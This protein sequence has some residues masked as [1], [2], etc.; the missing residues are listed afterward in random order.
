L[1]P[2]VCAVIAAARRS[3]CPEPGE[4]AL[5][6][7]SSPA[8]NS[9]R[10]SRQFSEGQVIIN[11]VITITR[12]CLRAFCRF[13]ALLPPRDRAFCAVIPVEFAARRPQCPMLPL[14][15]WRELTHRHVECAVIRLS[16]SA[17]AHVFPAARIRCSLQNCGTG[18]IRTSFH[19]LDVW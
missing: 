10:D 5:A 12:D 4:R 18:N 11:E 13:F 3:S 2:T 9:S 7:T 6:A 14:D 19:N 17:H 8:V 1:Q 16:R 15:Q